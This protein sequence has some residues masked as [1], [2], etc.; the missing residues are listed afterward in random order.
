M[1]AAPK[2]EAAAAETAVTVRIKDFKYDAATVRVAVGGTV[3]FKQLDA[4]VHTA[5]AKGEIPFD[6]GNLAKDASK[7]VTFDR[8]GR[9]DYICDIHQYMKGTIEVV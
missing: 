8:A 5:T 7:A 1:A 3:T 6:T 2:S 9:I 4:S